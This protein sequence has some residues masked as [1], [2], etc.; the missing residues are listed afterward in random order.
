MRSKHSQHGG[1]WRIWLW[2]HFILGWQQVTEHCCDLGA[3]LNINLIKQPKRNC[4]SCAYQF[5]H[6]KDT[7]FWSV[8][9]KG[10]GFSHW[11]CMHPPWW[12]VHEPWAAG[13]FPQVKTDDSVISKYNSVKC[14]MQKLWWEFI[15][16][17]GDSVAFKKFQNCELING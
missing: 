7:Q 9:Q 12:S 11:V 4:N 1:R 13:L 2:R 14:K 17:L 10:A 3:V 8:N 16:N 15:S 5:I 6:E